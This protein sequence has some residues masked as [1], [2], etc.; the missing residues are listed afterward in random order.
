[1][2]ENLITEIQDLISEINT[3]SINRSEENDDLIVT[4]ATL[5]TSKINDASKIIEANNLDNSD[6]ISLLKDFLL[7]V[8]DNLFYIDDIL[9]NIKG[10]VKDKIISLARKKNSR[11][12]YATIR[13]YL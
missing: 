2:Q 1:M 13:R 9:E 5:L 4:K 10:E 12:Q 3:L 7:S 6:D 8:K 11:N